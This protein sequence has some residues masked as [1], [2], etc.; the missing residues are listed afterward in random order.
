MNLSKVY[1]VMWWAGKM[2]AVLRLSLRQMSSRW[3]LLLIAL[4]SILPVA[5]AALIS[6]LAEGESDIGEDFTNIVVDGMLVGAILPIVTMALATSAFGHELDDHTLSYLAL[7]P[8]RRSLIVLPKMLASIIIA[9]PLVIASG[10]FA[11]LLGP[12]GSIEAAIGIGIALF[13]GVVTYTAIFTWAGL[14][15][16]RALGFVLIYVFLW[17]GIVSSFLEGVRYLSVRGYVLGIA[18]GI[19]EEGFAALDARAIELPAALAGAVAVT[20]FFF[21]LAVRRLCHMDVP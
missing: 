13:T 1:S 2:E 12:G 21:W 7:K 9:G 18:H 8:L 5:L 3:R 16:T 4:L 19:Y 11:I 15:T 17:E 20:A 6:A 10:I 14:I